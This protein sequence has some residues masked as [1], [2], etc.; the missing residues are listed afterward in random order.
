[1]P[2][3]FQNEK[4]VSTALVSAC[5]KLKNELFLK[6]FFM[7]TY[8]FILEDFIMLKRDTNYKLQIQQ[9]YS[10]TFEANTVQSR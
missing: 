5:F 4:R 9:Q 1:M 10:N 8:V 6:S 7:T 2:K 3:E